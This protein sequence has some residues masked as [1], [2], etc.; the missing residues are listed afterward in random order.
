MYKW[1]YTLYAVKFCTS[2][3][4]ERNNNKNSQKKIKL[5]KT[6]ETKKYRKKKT[7]ANRQTPNQ[8]FIFVRIQK[9]LL[10]NIALEYFAGGLKKVLK[11]QKKS[12]LG[13]PSKHHLELPPSLKLRKF[14]SK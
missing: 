6:D 5:N 1:L 2:E 9:I 4:E 14:L 10:F 13:S 11:I 12:G 7:Y 8:L 3:S